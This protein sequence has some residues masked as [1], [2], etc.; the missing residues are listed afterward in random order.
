MTFTATLESHQVIALEARKARA[1]ASIL[2]AL[3]DLG[4]PVDDAQTVLLDAYSAIGVGVDLCLGSLS[5]PEAAPLEVGPARRSFV[6]LEALDDPEEGEARP[7]V[8]VGPLDR[9]RSKDPK[10]GRQA[11]LL[12]LIRERGPI[13][14]SEILRIQEVEDRAEKKR[15]YTAISALIEAGAIVRDTD[16]NCRSAR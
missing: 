10:G 15:I 13:K 5:S 12:Q 9:P 11:G 16:G 4:L 7:V 3:D 14:S 1:R 8:E 2:T 6:R